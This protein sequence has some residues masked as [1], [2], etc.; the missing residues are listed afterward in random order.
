MGTH[1]HTHTHTHNKHKQT[2]RQRYRDADRHR[3][4][5]TD[6]DAGTDP[7]AK[8]ARYTQSSFLIRPPKGSEPLKPL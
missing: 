2:E 7:L 4:I 6:L 1:T 3:D 5:D 8:G